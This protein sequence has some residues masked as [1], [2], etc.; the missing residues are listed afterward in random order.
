[1]KIYLNLENKSKI[2]V[3]F[4]NYLFILVKFILFL[5]RKNSGIDHLDKNILIYLQQMRQHKA[6]QSHRNVHLLH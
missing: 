6:V 2:S 5:D 1:M 4:V 3:V